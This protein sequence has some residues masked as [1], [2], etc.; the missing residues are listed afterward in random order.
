[1]SVRKNVHYALSLCLAAG[2][3]ITLGSK[4]YRFAHMKWYHDRGKGKEEKMNHQIIN[5]IILRFLFS[6]IIIVTS[7]SA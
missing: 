5:I 6:I 3:V 1:M 7:A 4:S 2:H